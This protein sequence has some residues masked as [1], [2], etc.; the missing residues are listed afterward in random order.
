MQKQYNAKHTTALGAT[1][2]TVIGVALETALASA[3]GAESM[4]PLALRTLCRPL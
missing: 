4:E 3:L 1:L 2:G